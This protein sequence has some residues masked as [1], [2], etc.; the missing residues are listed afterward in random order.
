[1]VLGMG[2]AGNPQ[3][4]EVRRETPRDEGELA[5]RGLGRGWVGRGKRWLLATEISSLSPADGDIGEMEDI[6]SV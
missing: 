4:A 6:R 1:M 3:F 5:V 2:T